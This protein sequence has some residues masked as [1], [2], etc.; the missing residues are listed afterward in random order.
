MK[1]LI[2]LT[3]LLVVSG[4]VNTKAPTVIETG[5][6]PKDIQK[7]VDKQ[8]EATTIIDEK[9]TII[10]KTTEDGVVMDSAKEIIKENQIIIITSEALSGEAEGKNNLL[11]A[12][13]Q[14]KIDHDKIIDEKN[15]GFRRLMMW[16]KIFGAIM[17]PLGIAAGIKLTKDFFWVSIA[18]VTVI[19]AASVASFIEK[20][21]LWVFGFIVVAGIVS[22]VRQYFIQ[23]RATI[24]ATR[25]AEMTKERLREKD[26]DSVKELYGHGLIPGKV[27]QTQNATTVK[28][29]TDA[30]KV[31]LKEAKATTA[32]V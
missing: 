19:I 6:S 29:I 26:E 8:K 21:F 12:Y 11:M 9:A 31:I 27:S 1:K 25:A 24:E 22:A 32:K 4:C 10:I 13:K 20:H 14:L 17:I 2:L 7:L 18:G 15:S 30:R 5:S 28:L 23:K 3:T 16:L